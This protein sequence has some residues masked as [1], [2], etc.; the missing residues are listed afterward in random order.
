MRSML[1]E[2]FLC[3]AIGTARLVVV[4]RSGTM[5]GIA[6]AIFAPLVDSGSSPTTK[7]ATTMQACLRLSTGTP[8]ARASPGSRTHHGSAVWRELLQAQAGANSPPSDGLEVSNG[9]SS[10][11]AIEEEVGWSTRGQIDSIGMPGRTTRPS[12][13]WVGEGGS[14]AAIAGFKP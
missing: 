13:A 4:S 2:Q 11:T 9:R 8:D 14:A 12:T 5:S 6:G 7:A 1:L 10:T 3:R